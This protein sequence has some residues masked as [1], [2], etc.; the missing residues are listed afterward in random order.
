[1]RIESKL[2]KKI[3]YWGSVVIVGAVLGVSLQFAKAW[4]APAS[5]APG[6][7]VSGP[8]TTG[9][10]L[11]QVKAGKL[12]T[13]PT[14]AG[15]PN[16]TLVTK[17]YIEAYVLAAAPASTPVKGGHYGGCYQEKNADFS[18]GYG[19]LASWPITSCP[20]SGPDALPTCDTGYKLIILS[21]SQ[22]NTGAF[23]VD[24]MTGHSKYNDLFDHYYLATAC[25]KL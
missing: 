2:L 25:A 1:M 22:S 11:P 16:N 5:P 15:D 23:G 8:L 24:K 12:Q 19:G 9:G 14:V 10:G 7:N 17:G 4:T 3:T 6:G 13:A 20:G 18:L 21:Q